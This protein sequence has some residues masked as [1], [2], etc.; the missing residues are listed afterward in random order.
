VIGTGDVVGRLQQENDELEREVAR[1]RSTREALHLELQRLDDMYDE[2][3]RELERLRAEV[4]RYGDLPLDAAFLVHGEP[5][6]LIFRGPSGQVVLR[7]V[8]EGAATSTA[9]A[10]A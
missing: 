10:N 7:R 1:L 4:A 8:R 5:E 9:Q 3:G 2:R 6:Q